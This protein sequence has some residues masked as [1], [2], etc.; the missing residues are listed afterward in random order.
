MKWNVWK[1]YDTVDYIASN[2]HIY[3]TLLKKKEKK[4][5]ERRGKRYMY[6]N[7]YM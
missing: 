5:K 7:T 3:V 1:A 6:V 2:I 4:G